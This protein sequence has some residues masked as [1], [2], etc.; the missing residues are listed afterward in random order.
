MSVAMED[1]SRR[2]RITVDE[3]HRMAEAGS[4]AP[5][6]RVELIDGVII[7]VP[8]IGSAHAGT[9]TELDTLLHR[10]VGDRAIVRCQQPVEVGKYSEPQPDLALVATRA[11]FY[12]DSHPTVQDALLV[13]EVSDSTL[14]DD[15]RQKRELYARHGIQEYWVVDLVNGRLHVFRNPVAGDYAQA[16]TV[17]RPGTMDITALPGASIDLS[18]LFA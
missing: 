11:G 5:D 14:Q 17:D 2:H 16:L 6:A 7:D 18:S 3:Y 13:I 12:R 4:F 1:G 9:V 10:A 8:P 15:L